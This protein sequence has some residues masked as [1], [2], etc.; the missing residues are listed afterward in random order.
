MVLL[1][2]EEHVEMF[3]R[4]KKV[5]H[6]FLWRMIFYI[7]RRAPVDIPLDANPCLR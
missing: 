5:F 1:D 3:V 7:C 2:V 6:V 4:K